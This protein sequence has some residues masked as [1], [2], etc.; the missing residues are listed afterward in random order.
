MTNFTELF[1]LGFKD[2]C[3][4]IPPQAEL[5]E[6]SKIDERYLGKAPGIRRADGKWR[7]DQNFLKRKI[8]FEICTAWDKTGA[9]VGLLA[10]RFPGLDIDVLDKELSDF[11]ADEARQFLGAAPVRVGKAPKQLL[12]YRLEGDPFGKNLLT[13]TAPD[14]VEHKIEV[15]A[16]GQQYVIHGTHPEGHSYAFDECSAETLTTVSGTKM[17]D[18]MDHIIPAL[19][20]RGCTIGSRTSSSGNGAEVDQDSLK[21][22]I[23]LVREAVAVIP[24][25]C[26]RYGYV[27]FGYA[28]RAA[29]ADD[30]EQGRE[31]FVKWASRWEGG[32]PDPDY[33]GATYD[34]L[35]PPFRIGAPYLYGLAHEQ[36]WVGDAQAEFATDTPDGEPLKVKPPHPVPF[37]D[38]AITAGFMKAHGGELRYQ[39]ENKQFLIWE[40]S[41]WKPDLRGETDTRIT[42]VLVEESAR[43]LRVLNV[44]PYVAKG[45]SS[46]GTMNRVRKLLKTKQEIVLLN[47]QFD[48]DPW[49]LGVPD[50]T[51]DLK[52][53]RVKTPNPRDNITK[54]TS[55]GPAQGD[56][57]RWNSF[58]DEATGGDFDL[59]NYLQRFCGYLLTGSIKEHNISFFHGSGGN[60]KS[61]FLNAVSE[62]LGDYSGIAP[63]DTFMK[64]YGERHPTELAGLVGKR[65]VFAQETGEGRRW[66]EEKL[67]AIS[68]GDTISARFMHKNFFTFN[69]QFKL[70]FSGNHKPT[71]SNLDAAMK[72]R[73]NLVPFTCVPKV[74]DQQL[75]EKLKAEYPQILQW[76][77]EGCRQWQ[78]VGLNPPEKVRVATEEYFTEEDTLGRWINDN[79]RHDPLVK[80]ETRELY[81]DFASWA[82][83]MGI[84]PGDEKK[85]VRGLVNRGYDRRKHPRSRRSMIEGLRLLL[86]SEKA[87][88]DFETS[89]D[90]HYDA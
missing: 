76:M 26:D 89:G 14:G 34:G 27:K 52:T 84:R 45:I 56:A 60:G 2:L 67:K 8:T 68:G 37:S 69:P 3:S 29:C 28:V 44:S 53:G 71:I 39:P 42:G 78:E 15:L 36:G 48:A 6:G 12:M 5:V 51:V 30:P 10:K 62:V 64:S 72:R 63:M 17:L 79:C 31:I 11:I 19:Q 65:A 21:G 83:L 46:G 4:V 81:G 35:K 7:G 80:T 23:A 1:T 86:D 61:V 18:F 57:L 85:F 25:N 43:A 41:R 49:L 33:D 50:G 54:T 70:V 59:V 82:D 20:A 38:L 24:N 32:V 9:N 58:L 66:D 22:D 87:S 75:P 47:E 40:G 74:V 13:F 77:I 88:D 55:V 90:H 73:L 16:D